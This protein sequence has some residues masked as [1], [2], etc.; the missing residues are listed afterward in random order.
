MDLQFVDILDILCP[1]VN[2]A[3]RSNQISRRTILFFKFEFEVSVLRNIKVVAFGIAK[4]EELV[5]ILDEYL[6][7]LFA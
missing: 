2:M 1:M 3:L 7:F 5:I 4:L 6:S